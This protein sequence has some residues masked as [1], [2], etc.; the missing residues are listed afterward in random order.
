M[1]PDTDLLSTYPTYSPSTPMVCIVQT[2]KGRTVASTT[3]NNSHPVW[4]HVRSANDLAEILPVDAK[5]RATWIWENWTTV[6]S[7]C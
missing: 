1:R 6:P 5:D 2:F 7:S 3:P 4:R